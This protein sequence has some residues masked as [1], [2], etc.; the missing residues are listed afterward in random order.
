M[1]Y[2]L[3]DIDIIINRVL[4]FS[5]LTLLTMAVYLGAVTGL[6]SLIRRI[7]DPLVFFIATGFVAILFEP[8]RQQLQRGVNR[9]MYGDRDDP[10]AVLTRLSN[11][12]E[13]SPTPEMVLPSLAA[14]VSQALKLPYLAIH[15]KHNGDERVVASVGKP[16][17]EELIFPVVF[18]SETIGTLHMAPR[19]H[20]TRNSTVPT[21]G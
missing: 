14:T 21:V 18:Q 20:E 12:L 17:A 6:S 2:H 10:Y 11:T 8:I 5:S 19:A 7:S 3:W 9:L 13:Q 4:V 15:V 1:R 16:Q